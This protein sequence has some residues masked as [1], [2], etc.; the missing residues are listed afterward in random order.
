[1]II[2]KT[3]QNETSTSYI[4]CLSVEW[5]LNAEFFKRSRQAN[6]YMFLWIGKLCVCSESSAVFKI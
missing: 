3:G 1:L 2:I 5:I 6:V 4:V